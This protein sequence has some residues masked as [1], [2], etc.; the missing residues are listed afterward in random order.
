MSV[1]PGSCSALAIASARAEEYQV[2]ATGALG[3]LLKTQFEPAEPSTFGASG[4]NSAVIRIGTLL[5]STAPHRSAA[6]CATIRRCSPR[7]VPGLPPTG[8]TTVGSL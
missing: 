5:L 8:A 2:P 1:S 6:N 3:K 7:V 4:L